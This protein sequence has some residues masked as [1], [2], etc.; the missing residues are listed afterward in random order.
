VIDIETMLLQQL[1]NISQRERIA[2]IPP[3][4]TKG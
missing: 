4:G 3:D 1:L 2:K